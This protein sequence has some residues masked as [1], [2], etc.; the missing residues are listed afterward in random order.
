MA[1]R[2]DDIALG[3]LLQDSLGAGST[4]HS[5][6]GRALCF[7]VAMVEVHGCRRKATAT[8]GTRPVT[9]AV[10]KQCLC[11]PPLPFSTQATRRAR[12]RGRS[13]GV[14]SLRANSVAVRTDDVALRNLFEDDAR[15]AEHGSTRRQAEAL[16]CAVAVIEI[17]LVRG[18]HLAAV[19]TRTV[20]DFSEEL[21]RPVLATSDSVDLAASITSVV[22]DVHRSLLPPRHASPVS[23]I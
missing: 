20:S 3:C 22:L 17:H 14:P 9:E 4:D 6:D 5:R 2:A 1:V 23:N 8:V 13:Q 10:Q 11:S 19:A 16:R 15:W 18:K 12:S 21:H 7:R